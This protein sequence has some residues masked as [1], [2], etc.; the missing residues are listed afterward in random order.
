MA[1]LIALRGLPGSGKST[2]ADAWRE[3]D[4]AS[5]VVVNR[6]D[7]RAMLF[8]AEYGTP[9]NESEKLVTRVQR[10]AI[11]GALKAGNDVVV[12]DTNLRLRTLRD[13]R[14]IA[15]LAGADFSVDDECATAD[16][17]VCLERNARRTD[18]KPVP[19][20]VIITMHDK[21]VKNGLPDLPAVE[22]D[23]L[24]KAPDSRYDV[25]PY[26]PKSGSLN[27]YIFDIDGT[28]AHRDHAPD[29]PMRGKEVVQ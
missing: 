29:C 16:L 23:D 12:D 26:T 9:D 27:A 18:K 8:G 25:E 14:R 4:P 10:E 17:E 6:D 22:D 15:I 1:R 7:I 2:Y 24:L 19:Q 28:L 11:T 20:R 3:Q 13:L 5:R 21:F